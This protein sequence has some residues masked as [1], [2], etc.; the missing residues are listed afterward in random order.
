[1]FR[2]VST[3]NQPRSWRGE[4]CFPEQLVGTFRAIRYRYLIVCDFLMTPF[5]QIVRKFLRVKSC[6]DADA[7][8]CQQNKNRAS[9]RASSTWLHWKEEFR[10]RHHGPRVV[11]G[12][13]LPSRRLRI[14]VC[15]DTTRNS[16]K[17]GLPVPPHRSPSPTRK[18]IKQQLS[19]CW[20]VALLLTMTDVSR[21][22]TSEDVLAR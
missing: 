4:A 8:I 12:W 19:F 1:M 22:L 11:V 10:D 9:P 14:F 15:V 3:C 17:P 20:G 18:I 6:P 13:L 21:R 5:R 7:P 2:V 16:R